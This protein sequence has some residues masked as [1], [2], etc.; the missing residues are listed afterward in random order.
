MRR[1]HLDFSVARGR[2]LFLASACVTVAVVGAASFLL[3]PVSVKF[4]VSPDGFVPFLSLNFIGLTAIACLQSTR[5]LHLPIIFAVIVTTAS[6]VPIVEQRYHAL[7]AID[8]AVGGAGFEGKSTAAIQIA[9]SLAL[10][11]SIV[12]GV[13]ASRVLDPRVRQQVSASDVDS[14]SISSGAMPFSGARQF[15]PWAG[16]VLVFGLL[17]A[18]YFPDIGNDISSWKYMVYPQNWD[19]TNF[20][21]WNWLGSQG[22]KTLRD[23]WYPY[24]NSILFFANQPASSFWRYGYEVLEYF[25]LYLNFF[26]LTGRKSFWPVI[27]V[28][29][30][31]V[32]SMTQT[33]GGEVLFP[34]PLRYLLGI[35]VALA[36]V[37][38]NHRAERFRWGHVWFGFLCVV[39]LFFE[40]SQTL[41]AGPA[42]AVLLFIDMIERIPRR[43]RDLSQRLVRDFSIPAL[44]L[45][46]NLVYLAS[47]NSLTA[48]IDFYGRLSDTAAYSSI[49]RGLSR[50]LSHPLGIEFLIVVAPMVLVS[51]GIFERLRRA[52]GDPRLGGFLI[53]VGLFGFMMLQKHIIRPMDQHL[54]IIPALGMMGYWLLRTDRRSGIEYA[55]SGICA[56]IFVTMLSGGAKL[57]VPGKQVL[58][59]PTR[60]KSSLRFYQTE[61]LAI[62]QARAERFAPERFVNHV[63]EQKLAAWMTVNTV[64]GKIPKIY[65][66]GDE[67]ITYILLR[68]RPPSQINMYNESPIYEQVKVIEWL[69]RE[70]PDYVVWNPKSL[71]DE[72]PG[73][74]DKIQNF[75]RVP[76]IYNE[77]IASFV[78]TSTVG[79]FEVLR[80]RKPDEA[81][82]VAYW[83]EQLGTTADFGHF[84][85][86]SSYPKFSPCDSHDTSTCADFLRVEVADTKILGSKVSIPIEVDGLLFVVALDTVPGERLYYVRMERLWFWGLL[87]RNGYSPKLVVAPLSK[88]PADYCVNGA[89]EWSGDWLTGWTYST[90]GVFKAGSA[91]RGIRFALPPQGQGYLIKQGFDTALLGRR[92]RVTARA[93]AFSPG[94]LA[95]RVFWDGGYTETTHSGNGLWEDLVVRSTTLDLNPN[96]TNQA[97]FFVWVGPASSHESFVESVRVEYESPGFEA[98]VVQRADRPEILY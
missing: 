40:P 12:L 7:S 54:A 96:S 10:C 33:S 11:I 2:I 35:N 29:T 47:I 64:N 61:S 90:G 6:I 46:C 34:N 86:V 65:V 38:I 80:P 93:K 44:F 85:R 75:I 91:D 48:Y 27:V 50:G 97:G 71:R 87:K 53:G 4:L 16:P 8:T 30:I 22:Y 57:G 37:V 14:R 89:L 1:L 95:L 92:V 76:L 32:G 56:A 63:D 39:S 74:F 41:S 23:F 62:D 52:G 25:G 69:R 77:V 59:A 3:K 67:A 20:L 51:L 45:L 24:G 9:A 43:W 66:L 42:V 19:I 28:L 55:A 58:A 15:L 73:T 78:P 68:Q 36:Y 88:E 94:T 98:T 79:V 49:A 60:I 81:I 17:A 31:W 26:V 21:V 18:L 13:L 84:G 72:K 82:P 5:R 83:R 70:K